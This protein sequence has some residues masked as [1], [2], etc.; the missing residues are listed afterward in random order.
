ML[1]GERI[2]SQ[3]HVPYAQIAFWS[4]ASGLYANPP[5]FIATRRVHQTDE[6]RTPLVH[7][8]A[9]LISMS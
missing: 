6:Y 9:F 7:G 2:K 5:N 1:E 4:L 8:F 3:Q